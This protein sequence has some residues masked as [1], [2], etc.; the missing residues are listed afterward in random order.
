MRVRLAAAASTCSRAASV[1]GAGC[2]RAWGGVSVARSLARV[3]V[4]AREMW[5]GGGG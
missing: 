1:V 3:C 2:K 5:G 4:H